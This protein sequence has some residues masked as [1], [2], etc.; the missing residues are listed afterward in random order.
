MVDRVGF[1]GGGVVEG[2][3]LL[4][5]STSDAVPRDRLCEVEPFLLMSS[6]FRLK[7][8][9]YSK[10]FAEV[11]RHGDFHFTGLM[12]EYIGLLIW[13]DSLLTLG[14]QFLP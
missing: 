8:C 3:D 9:K 2:G 12:I 11:S 6:R 10:S 7:C 1:F 14:I 4:S 5:S 13:P